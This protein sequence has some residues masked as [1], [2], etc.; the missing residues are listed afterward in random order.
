MYKTNNKNYR[1]KFAFG[2]NTSY[3]RYSKRVVEI[4]I[5]EPAFSIMFIPQYDTVKYPFPPFQ[6]NL[7]YVGEKYFK[8]DK[9]RIEGFLQGEIIFFEYP[10][11]QEEI[12]KIEFDFKSS[13]DSILKDHKLVYCLDTETYDFLINDLRKNFLYAPEDSKSTVNG[14]WKHECLMQAKSMQYIDRKIKALKLNLPNSVK[15]SLEM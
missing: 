11:K 7:E 3:Q 15:K 14:G 4:V 12:F 8:S 6:Y 9:R 10:D 13:D 5:N 1:A 2:N